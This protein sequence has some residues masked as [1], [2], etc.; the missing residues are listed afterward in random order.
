MSETWNLKLTSPDGGE[1]ELELDDFNLDALSPVTHNE[2]KN[3]L[4]KT[5]Y[6][7]YSI[8]GIHRRLQDVKE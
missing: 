2:D 4:E 3:T 8:V 6:T 1:I 7:F 5:P